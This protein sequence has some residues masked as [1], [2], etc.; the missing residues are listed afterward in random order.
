MKNSLVLALLICGCS[1]AAIAFAQTAPAPPPSDS[2]STADSDLEDDEIV[3]IAGRQRGAVVG[4]VA[5][6]VSYS[7]GDVRAL[8]VSSVSD[9][10]SELAPQ[11]SGGASN[12]RPVVLINGLRTTGYAEVRDLPTEAIMRVDIYPAEL[13]LRY[14]YRADQ[15]VVNIVLRN[16][17]NATVVQFAPTIATAGGRASVKAQ[18]TKLRID[19]KKRWS[20]DGQYQHDSPLFESERN[21]LNNAP[22]GGLDQRPWR[23]LLARTDTASLNGSMTSTIKDG[24][25]ATLNIRGEAVGTQSG[26]GA[27]ANGTGG[28]VPLVRDSDQ[29]TGHVGAMVNGALSGWQWSLTGNYDIVGTHSTTDRAASIR[30]SARST[31]QTGKIELVASGVLVKLPAGDMTLTGQAGAQAEGYTGTSVRQVAS[32]SSELSRRTG[33]AQASIDVPIA[34]SRNHALQPL[35]TLSVNMNAAI[36][37]LSDFGN[38]T[39][40]GYGLNWAPLPVINLV[41]SVTHKEDAPTMQQLGDP[42]LVTPNARIFDYVQQQTVDIARTDGGNR[43]LLA[44]SSHIYSLETTLRPFGDSGPKLSV[45]YLNEDTRNPIVSFPAATAAVEAAFPG[46]FGRNGA[47]QLVSIDA[48][49]VN[50][51]RSNT[52]QLRWGINFSGRLGKAPAS[53]GD[54]RPPDAAN[55]GTGTKPGGG[56]GFG[57][58]GGGFSGRARQARV[59][60]SLYHTWQMRSD[61]QLQSGGTTLDLLNGAAVGNGGGTPRHQVDL[62]AGLTKNGLGFRLNGKWQ[63]ATNVRGAT[64][65]AGDLRFSALGTMG[66]QLSAQLGAQREWVQQHPWM[67][68]LRISLNVDNVMDTR[69]Q[70]HNANGLTPVNY[71]PDYLNPLGRTIRLSIRKVFF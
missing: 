66:V 50:F 69:Q 40:W 2:A 44:E 21:L 22:P 60:F 23:S 48:R 38:L 7:A 12:G 68:G 70:V 24:L 31:A 32:V 3:V 37:R 6:D 1:H 20:I 15:R 42:L 36:D 64:T 41:A 11:V 5:P 28:V 47:G 61:I 56:R 18:A 54:R 10:L 26:V 33:S 34:S 29:Q 55:A 63:S 62:Q 25:Y 58:A 53:S 39:T 27:L 51:A 30:D 19:P 17:F 59:Q 14:G 35:G 65:G 8:G 49:P 4:N 57:G 45:N 13:A 16:R 71:Q 46:R 52:E 9:L 67:R 43:A